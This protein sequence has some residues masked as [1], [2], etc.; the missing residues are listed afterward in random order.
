MFTSLQKNYKF[1]F[2]FY[3]VLKKRSS[4][5]SKLEHTSQ[6]ILS[7]EDLK[8]EKQMGKLESTVYYNSRNQ[9][10]YTDLSSISKWYE[11]KSISKSKK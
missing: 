10:K 8:Y 1:G 5:L 7:R 9:I 4:Y 11:V 6:I 2:N 3:N